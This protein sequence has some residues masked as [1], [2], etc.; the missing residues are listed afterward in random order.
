MLRVSNVAYNWVD[1]LVTKYHFRPGNYYL[2]EIIT[3]ASREAVAATS[4]RKAMAAI[5]SEYIPPFA[6]YVFTNCVGMSQHRLLAFLQ[7]STDYKACLA[8][9]EARRKRLL[10]NNKTNEAVRVKYIVKQKPMNE[11]IPAGSFGV[12]KE[13]IARSTESP[14]HL[15]VLYDMFGNTELKFWKSAAKLPPILHDVTITKRINGK[16]ILNI[17]C[18]R[19]YTQKPIATE[20]TAIC[21]VDPGARTFLTV[22]DETNHEAYKLGVEPERCILNC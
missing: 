12:Q 13:Y 21:G 4:R 11:N 15:R 7:Y 22:F 14:R 3:R 2:Q 10:A 6:R 19:Q 20:P 9:E 18:P 16:W 1:Y 17:P 5:P 8:K